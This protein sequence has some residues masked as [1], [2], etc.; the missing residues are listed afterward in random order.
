MKAEQLMAK[1]RN[2][3]KQTGV[4]PQILLKSFMFDSFAERLSISPYKDNFVLKRGFYLPTLFGL[5]KRATE[6]IDVILQDA[7]LTEGNLTG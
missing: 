7:S 1:L 6:D 5:T 3:S 2:L 4:S